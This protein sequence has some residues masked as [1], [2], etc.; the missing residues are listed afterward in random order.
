MAFMYIKSAKEKERLK[1]VQPFIEYMLQMVEK[2]SQDVQDKA[3]ITGRDPR[4]EDSNK[5]R[6]YL[7]KVASVYSFWKARYIDHVYIY[8]KDRI[9]EYKRIDKCIMELTDDDILYLNKLL[10]EWV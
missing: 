4:E 10:L 7:F 5:D 9:T 8:I 6:V 2:N 1:H 3:T